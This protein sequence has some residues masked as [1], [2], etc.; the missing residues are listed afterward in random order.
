MINPTVET[1]VG[2]RQYTLRMMRPRPVSAGKSFP[3]AQRTS[4]N[5]K[6]NI[7]QALLHKIGLLAEHHARN[8]QALH[9]LRSTSNPPTAWE[10][11]GDPPPPFESVSPGRTRRRVSNDESKMNGAR[12][13]RQPPS[14]AFTRVTTSDRSSWRN[15]PT[16]VEP[17]RGMEAHATAWKRKM[18]K[19]DEVG[20]MHVTE[21]SGSKDHQPSLRD[22]HSHLAHVVDNVVESL[23]E[24]DRGRFSN[25]AE[26]SESNDF[27]HAEAGRYGGLVVPSLA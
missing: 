19:Y 22:L 20:A 8:V 9:A 2:G 10:G 6:P 24:G 5:C 27:V 16:V 13:A 21:H 12:R 25:I 26:L 18:R 17:F 14:R 7:E 11:V 15:K 3:T 1:C 23:P 4:T